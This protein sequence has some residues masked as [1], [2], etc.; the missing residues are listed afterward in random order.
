LQYDGESIG[1]TGDEAGH[2]CKMPSSHPNVGEA[3]ALCRSQRSF[4]WDQPSP[5]LMAPLLHCAFA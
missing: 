3:S 2:H 1:I 4:Q 5:H